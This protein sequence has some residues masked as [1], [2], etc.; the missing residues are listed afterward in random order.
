MEVSSLSKLFT[1]MTVG[2]E[3][4]E[5]LR[6]GKD[7]PSSGFETRVFASGKIVLVTVAGSLKVKISVLVSSMGVILDVFPL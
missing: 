1:V 6:V 5:E 7:F 4:T 3:S 2:V